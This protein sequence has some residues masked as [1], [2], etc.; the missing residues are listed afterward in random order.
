MNRRRHDRRR[1]PPHPSA[2]NRLGRG[3]PA[4]LRAASRRIPPGPPRFR[5]RQQ[6]SRPRHSRCGLLPDTKTTNLTML[7]SMSWRLPSAA[8][9]RNTA[10]LTP[11]YRRSTMK[12]PG[13][14]ANCRC[15]SAKRAT[16]Q[17]PNAPL[18]NRTPRYGPNLSAQ[19][20][21]GL[22]LF[23]QSSRYTFSRRSC[24]SCASMESVAIGLASRRLSAICSP[25]SSQ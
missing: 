6:I 24:R 3:P 2:P 20:T 14:S 1:P 5:R 12:W 15:R 4:H 8:S 19:P 22:S 16:E 21:Q 9:R 7:C 11:Q 13:C 18:G 17:E 23:A 25:V 10:S